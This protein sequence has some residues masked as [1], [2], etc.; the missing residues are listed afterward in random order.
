MSEQNNNP[1]I[2]PA[3]L[4]NVSGSGSEVQRAIEIDSLSTSNTGSSVDVN[5][6]INS[7]D[8]M[9]KLAR[10]VYRIIRDELMIERERGFGPGNGKFF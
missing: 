2:K 6:I 7:Q 9:D 5:D 3:H 8:N 10:K 4:R 1:P